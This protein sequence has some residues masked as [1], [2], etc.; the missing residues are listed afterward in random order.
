MALTFWRFYLNGVLYEKV[1]C[2]GRYRGAI[3]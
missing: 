2:R 1:D 3:F